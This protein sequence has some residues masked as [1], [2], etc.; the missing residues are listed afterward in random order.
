MMLFESQKR[1]SMYTAHKPRVPAPTLYSPQRRRNIDD[2]W[3]RPGFDRKGYFTEL[4]YIRDQVNKIWFKYDVNRSGALDKIETANFLKDFCAAQRK[5]APNMQTF[6]RFFF[7]FDKN[8]DGL[9]Q[10]QEMARF[11]KSFLESKRNFGTASSNQLSDAYIR[12]QV[13]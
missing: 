8:R 5:P 12:E 6:H 4:D 10:K 9:I 7:D 1:K 11:I 2:G 13:D 3:D